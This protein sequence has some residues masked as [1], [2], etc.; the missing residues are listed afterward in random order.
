MTDSEAY[1]A[2]VRLLAASDKTPAEL[3]ER[4]AA[5]GIDEKEASEAI[6]RLKKEGFLNELA[7]AEKTVRRLYDGCYGKEYIRA[8][9]QNKKFSDD[10][11]DFAESI[12]DQ[13]DFDKSAKQ[14]FAA[15]KKAGKTHAQALSALYKRGFSDVLPPS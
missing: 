6:E 12:M 14:Y 7:Y 10:A 8:Y 11:L 2:A 15:M 5:K 13:L 1:R 4:L 9:L 3:C